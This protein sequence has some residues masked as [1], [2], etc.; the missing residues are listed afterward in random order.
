M[1]FRHIYTWVAIAWYKYHRGMLA[2][3][4]QIVGQLLQEPLLDVRCTIPLE[5]QTIATEIRLLSTF[6][7]ISQGSFTYDGST[8]M[9]YGPLQLGRNVVQDSHRIS[10]K[11]LEDLPRISMF[12]RNQQTSYLSRCLM[13]NLYS[14]TGLALDMN[15][16][17]NATN[18]CA[19]E[20]CLA[21]R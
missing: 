15:R 6:C 12:F 17:V 18:D 8:I 1:K 14:W 11:C 10:T 21:L 7:R 19:Q 3:A 13:T 16:M 5:N 2:E 4:E 20:I 9:E